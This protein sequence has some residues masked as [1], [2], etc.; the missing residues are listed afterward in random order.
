M[1]I[2]KMNKRFLIIL[3]VFIML[4]VLVYAGDGRNE[5]NKF[6]TMNVEV[7]TD[8]ATL[9]A[10]C[11]WC[12]EAVFERLEGVLEVVS[13]YSGGHVNNPSYEEVCTGNTGHAEVCQIIFDP[14][15][16]SFI[17]ILEVFWKTHDP[18]TLNR[19]GADVGTQYRSAIF[20]HSEEQRKEAEYHKNKLNESGYYSDP[21]VTEI[22]PFDEFFKAGNYHQEYYKLHGSQPYCNLVIKPKVE[23]FEILFENKIKRK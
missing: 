14:D 3:P 2:R 1:Q 21:V 11:F 10:G 15:Q 9:A 17:E 8:T 4:G 7:K 16:I 13:G 22:V 6:M 18:T 12:V 19:Q 5:I 20:Y 23:K